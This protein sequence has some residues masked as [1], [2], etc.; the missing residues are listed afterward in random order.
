M[1][2][3]DRENKLEVVFSKLGFD[4]NQRWNPIVE[5]EVF[6]IIQELVANCMKHA[7]ASKLL[8]ELIADEKMLYLS[9]EDNGVG[10]DT[11]SLGKNS[12]GLK[13]IEARIN[14]LGGTVSFDSQTN[15]GT[16]VM[17]NT[18]INS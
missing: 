16:T 15:K 6:K 11:D 18:P 3:R 9:V 1:C 4:Q 8:I 13:N 10:F 7:K 12:F 2:I 14:L 5:T 17:I